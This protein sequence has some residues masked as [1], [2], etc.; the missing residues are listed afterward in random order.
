[1]KQKKNKYSYNNAATIYFERGLGL[2]SNSEEG[3][4]EM[5]VLICI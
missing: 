5:G 4:F 2:R 1:M 3:K